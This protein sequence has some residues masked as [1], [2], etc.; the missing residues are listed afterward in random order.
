[1]HSYNIFNYFPSGPLL[2]IDQSDAF[3]RLDGSTKTGGPAGN[4]FREICVFRNA[5]VQKLMSLSE[6]DQS[7]WDAAVFGGVPKN[8]KSNYPNETLQPNLHK[9]GQSKGGQPQQQHFD[10]REMVVHF[11][12]REMLSL[13]RSRMGLARDHVFACLQKYRPQDV[14]F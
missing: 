4:F 10:E 12:G 6:L 14:L 7:S 2:G 5:T 13:V 9:F 11:F 8:A 3:F 1:M